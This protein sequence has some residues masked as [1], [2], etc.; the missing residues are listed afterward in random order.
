MWQKSTQ[1]LFIFVNIYILAV[2]AY[3]AR[4]GNNDIWAMCLIYES[5]ESYMSAKLV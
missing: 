4:S 2:Q 1:N 5:W 3:L